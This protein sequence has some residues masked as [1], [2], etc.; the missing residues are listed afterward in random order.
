MG[1]ELYA[2]V[3]TRTQAAQGKVTKTV[4]MDITEGGE[5][6][7]RIEIGLFGM[8]SNNEP[9]VCPLLLWQLCVSTCLH[10]TAL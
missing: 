6:M 9:F 4:F 5:P 10:G 3:C 8:P 1:A 7:G 2:L